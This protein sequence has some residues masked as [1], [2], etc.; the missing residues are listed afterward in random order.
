MT[1]LDLLS[2][3]ELR[4]SADNVTDKNFTLTNIS[5]SYKQ[6]DTCGPLVSNHMLWMR[7]NEHALRRRSM[8]P[9]VTYKVP[10]SLIASVSFRHAVNLGQTTN[11]V[12][13]YHGLYVISNSPL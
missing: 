11:P 13:T 7:G 3:Y 6:K 8:V 4:R 10:L 9:E 1:I 5:F 12:I 2:T